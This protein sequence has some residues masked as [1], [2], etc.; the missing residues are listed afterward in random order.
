MIKYHK[1][2]ICAHGFT[3]ELCSFKFS[4]HHSTRCALGKDT[5]DWSPFVNIMPFINF[6]TAALNTVDQFLLFSTPYATSAN[7]KLFS[8][9]FVAPFYPLLIP[10]HIPRP[11]NMRTLRFKFASLFLLFTPWERFYSNSMNLNTMH[12][13]LTFKFIYL[14]W[15]FSLSSRLILI[16]FTWMSAKQLKLSVSNMKLQC[17]V[18]SLPQMCFS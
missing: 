14:A 5:G 12:M 6:S 9:S 10:S 15:P 2:G 8:I 4:L 18:P 1:R 16:I 17:Y 13:L 3:H 7:S 11:V